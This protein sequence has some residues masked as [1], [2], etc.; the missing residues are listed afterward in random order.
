[1]VGIKVIPPTRATQLRVMTGSHGAGATRTTQLRVMV[2]VHANAPLCMTTE[3]EAW[4]ITRADGQVF[5]FTSH[6]RDVTFN[7][8]VYGTCGGMTASALQLSATLGEVDN[9]DLSGLITANKIKASDIWA[10]RFAGAEVEVWRVDWKDP[11]FG[12]QLMAGRIG[13]VNFADTTFKFEVVTPAER[14]QQASVLQTVTPS[15]RYKLGDGRCGVN[16]A[17]FTASGAVTA[18]SLPNLWLMSKR[19]TFIDSSR[20]EADDY[21]QLGTLTWLTG[22]NAGQTID[23]RSFSAGQFVLE[24]ATQYDIQIGDTY[25]AVKGCDKSLT[26]CDTVFSNSLNFGG[27]PYVRGTDD[28]QDS[29]GAEV[30]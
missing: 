4:K 18:V 6:D 7:G 29:P 5:R 12:R 17:A 20:A 27:F 10:G 2:G 14:L 28:L 16:L 3:C 21:W 9:L 22:N 13:E 23:I 8:E 15:C 25:E 19:R 1:M 30:E 26:V 11:T 24:Q